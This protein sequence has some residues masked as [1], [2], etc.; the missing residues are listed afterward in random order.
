MSLNCLDNMLESRVKDPIKPSKRLLEGALRAF[1]FDVVIQKRFFA[2]S[3]Q[4]PASASGKLAPSL[5]RSVLKVAI[6][7]YQISYYAPP[8]PPPSPSLLE[9]AIR[10]TRGAPWTFSILVVMRSE[11]QPEKPEKPEIGNKLT[12]SYGTSILT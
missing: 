9:S 8:H 5:L 6:T 12:P 11:I 1:C 4:K 7:L 10:R 3:T 2:C